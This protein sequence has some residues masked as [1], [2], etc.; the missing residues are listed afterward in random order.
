MIRRLATLAIL[1]A[2][3]TN[4]P[5]VD[6]QVQGGKAIKAQTQSKR[7]P[8]RE[9][10]ADSARKAWDSAK[11]LYEAQ[12]FQG[13]LV[14]FQRAYDLSK[15]PR[16]LFNIGVC[17][18]NLRRYVRAIARWNQQLAESAGKL[19]TT[20]EQEI[21]DAIAALQQFV[22]SI[23]IT[24][25]EAGATILVDGEEAGTTPLAGPL[26]I[27]VGRHT[28][29]LRKDG[30]QEQQ[31]LVNVASGKTDQTQIKLEPSVRKGL[32][33]VTLGEGQT[34]NIFIDGID[35]GPAPY[36]GEVVAGRHTFEARSPGHVTARQTS[37]V[38]YGQ[39]VNLSFNMSS[40]RHEGKLKISVDQPDAIIS[41]DGKAVGTGT[42]EG[43]L[44]SG[45]HQLVIKKPGY[46]TYSQEIN[47][48]DDQTRNVSIPM[49]TEQRGASWIWW[50]AGAVAVVAG[51]AVASYFV[52]K[53]TEQ[54]PVSGTFNPGLVPG[55]IR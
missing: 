41:I 52:F 8:I 18:K 42:W 38:V 12:D 16:V 31:V 17:E 3:S 32:V 14:E 35:M 27:D 47:L 5:W 46:Q 26:P 44:G 4:A 23:Q 37:D 1:F 9:E 49:V 55:S 40:E 22:S 10:L 19:T 33:A 15:N 20:E 34:A 39:T 2:V 28:V 53:P 51:G 45:G 30:F 54:T 7:V 13:A 29:K 21:K 48:S 36:K 11:E 43:V 24:S 6:A 50:T 25:N